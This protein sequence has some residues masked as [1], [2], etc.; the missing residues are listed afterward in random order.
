MAFKGG[1]L[2]K[3]TD[4]GVDKLGAL[5]LNGVK[6]IDDKKRELAKEDETLLKESK[7][8]VNIPTTGISNYDTMMAKYGMSVQQGIQG[9]YDKLK[10]GEIS[11]EDYKLALVSSK[12]SA[13]LMSNYPTI[14]AKQHED[15]KKGIEEGRLSEINLENHSGRFKDVNGS[16]DHKTLSIDAFFE[17]GRSF[18]TETYPVEN[19][20]GEYEIETSTIDITQLADPNK[21]LYP[22]FDLQKEIEKFTDTLNEQ[23]VIRVNSVTQ[24]DGTVVRKIVKDP[25]KSRT[26]VENIDRRVALVDESNLVDVLFKLGARSRQSQNFKQPTQDDIN[27]RFGSNVSISMYDYENERVGRAI[28]IEPNDLVLDLSPNG[29]INLTQKQKDIARGVV[30]ASMYGSLGVDTQVSVEEPKLVKPTQEE[31]NQN[32]T[33]EPSSVDVYSLN[34]I[35]KNQLKKASGISAT[36]SDLPAAIQSAIPTNNSDVSGVSVPQEYSNDIISSI[37]PVSF[38]GNRLTSINSMIITK[39]KSEG[40]SLPGAPQ[41]DKYNIILVGPSVI[42]DIEESIATEGEGRVAT[43][44]SAEGV[45]I[46]KTSEIASEVSMTPPLE[47]IQAQSLYLLYYKGNE[48]FRKIADKKGFFA[49]G[50]KNA[51][52]GQQYSQAM[53]IIGTAL[54]TPRSR[55]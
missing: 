30:R 23:G 1:F 55:Q 39:T 8:A 33:F 47:E 53:Y 38:S 2:L 42:G 26:V 52:L 24:S 22:R 44:V 20:N 16:P 40:P 6:A 43:G 36:I 50:D 54:G 5:Y 4:T 7:A 18:I 9:L 11:R 10:R 37:S 49:Q 25:T 45:K 48:Q 35:A 28:N 3:P 21:I 46:K 32:L 29:K 31:L 13:E 15:I 27:N 51:A 34:T 17:N 14:I 12:T 19:E 41:R